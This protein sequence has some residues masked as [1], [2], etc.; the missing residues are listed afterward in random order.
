MRIRLAAVLAAAVL[1]SAC[2]ARRIP[3]TEIEDND[4][5]R[6][7]INVME[8]YRSSLE[9]RDAE[10]VLQL[11]SPEFRDDAGTTTPA[12]D[13]SYEELKQQLPARLGQLDNVRLD[14]NVRKIE[15]VGDLAQ[16]VYYYNSSYKLPQLS[17]RA[18]SDSDL[19]MM[20]LKRVDDDWRIISGL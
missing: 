14:V 12:D 18:Q 7:I 2:A 8:K 4:E 17:P 13:V 9:A 6:A 15:I 10:G 16:V 11:I 19:Q 5:T 20:Q 3:G 1:L